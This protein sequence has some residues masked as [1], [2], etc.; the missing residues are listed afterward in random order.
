MSR[1]D[2]LGIRPD[3]PLE[4]WRRDAE[5]FERKRAFGREEMKREEQRASNAAGWRA[6]IAAAVSAEHERMIEI[7]GQVLGGALDSERT[8]ITRELAAKTSAFEVAIAKAEAKIAKLELRIAELDL[9]LHK[10]VPPDPGQRAAFRFARERE[11]TDE[12][13]LPRFLPKRELN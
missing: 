13:D 2:P 8:E 12:Q 7:V 5:E 10:R 9:A 3:D 4:K 1:F 6:E 11:Q